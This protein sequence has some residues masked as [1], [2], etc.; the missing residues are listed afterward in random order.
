M[1]VQVLIKLSNTKEE[2][3]GTR[4]TFCI[5]TKFHILGESLSKMTHLL[6]MQHGN[7]VAVNSLNTTVNLYNK[8]V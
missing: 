4:P 1:Y 6:Y 7:R 2:F 5:L 8:H 3:I